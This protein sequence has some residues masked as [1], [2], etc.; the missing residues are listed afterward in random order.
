ML[1]VQEV[2][3]GS[4]QALAVCPQ[5]MVQVVP[6]RVQARNAVQ[7]RNQIVAPDP[8]LVRNNNVR[9]LPN[10]VQRGN[11]RQQFV[12]P[13]TGQPYQITQRNNQIVQS[14]PQVNTQF[15]VPNTSSAT[16]NIQSSYVATNQQS[17]QNNTD[18]IQNM[19]QRTASN[20]GVQRQGQCELYT[21]I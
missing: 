18:H 3:Q 7:G 17:P 20:R 10:Q 19:Q 14:P 15:R 4:G 1:P 12:V 5:Q 13:N 16:G 2:I 9:A 6:S 8:V 21:C 11:A